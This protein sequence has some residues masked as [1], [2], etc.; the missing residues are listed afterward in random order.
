MIHGSENN[1]AGETSTNMEQNKGSGCRY[2]NMNMDR[3]EQ[4][5]ETFHS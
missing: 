4:G 2:R 3:W 1:T 5:V